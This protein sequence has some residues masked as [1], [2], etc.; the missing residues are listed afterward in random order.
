[1][2]IIETFIFFKRLGVHAQLASSLSVK[3][4]DRELMKSASEQRYY[5]ILSQPR[6]R[7]DLWR[8]TCYRALGGG[9][10]AIVAEGGLCGGNGVAILRQIHR[11]RGIGHFRENIGCSRVNHARSTLTTISN[12]LMTSALAMRSG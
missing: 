2:P 1:M 10:D 4:T 7:V 12:E 5:E 8:T 6:S 9:P 3:R 11:G